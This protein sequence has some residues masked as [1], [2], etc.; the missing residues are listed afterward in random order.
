[1]KLHER[2][3][4]DEVGDRRA[5]PGG[6]VYIEFSHPETADPANCRMSTVFV[7]D[8]H[9]EHVVLAA[10]KRRFCGF[11]PGEPVAIVDQ[12][13]PGEVLGT[14]ATRE[15]LPLWNRALERTIVPVAVG[16]QIRWTDYSKLRRLPSE[17]T[18]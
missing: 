18:P 6:W 4:V 14:V 11:A 9:A 15:Q 10:T 2:E 12:E 8:E 1:M 16:D 7:P 3:K 17:A 5:V 13:V